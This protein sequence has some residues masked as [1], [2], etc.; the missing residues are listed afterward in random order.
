VEEHPPRR[1]GRGEKIGG[2]W[3]GNQERG[4]HLKY[5]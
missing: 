4:K 2:L 3:M 5:K 1:R